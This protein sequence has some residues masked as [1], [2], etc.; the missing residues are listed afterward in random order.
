MLWREKQIGR[1]KERA[2]TRGR[3]TGKQT[4]RLVGNQSSRQT[5]WF[6]VYIRCNRKKI[7]WKMKRKRQPNQRSYLLGEKN[8]RDCERENEWGKEKGRGRQRQA[9]KKTDQSTAIQNRGNDGEKETDRQSE[10]GRASRQTLGGGG[11]FILWKRLSGLTYKCISGSVTHQSSQGIAWF[12]KF[13][14]CVHASTSKVF[15]KY[16]VKMKCQG[17]GSGL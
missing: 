3:Q 15:W 7:Y 9:D 6:A 16:I 10:R 2:R 13:S 8:E 12:G 17:G 11:L 14:K 4:D 1:G 5:N